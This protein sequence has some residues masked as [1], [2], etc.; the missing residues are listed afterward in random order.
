MHRIGDGYR[1]SAKHLLVQLFLLEVFQ[2]PLEVLFIHSIPESVA[3]DS[4]DD[5]VAE[6]ILLLELLPV[7]L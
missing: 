4:V 7:E 6:D 5:L 3:G 1:A 2:L